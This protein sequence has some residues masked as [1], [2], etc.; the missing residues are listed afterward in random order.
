[1]SSAEAWREYICKACGYVYRERDGDIDSGLAP[2]TRF[3]EIPD[4]WYCPICGVTKSDFVLVASQDVVVLTA[5]SVTTHAMSRSFDV[6]VVGGGTAAWRCV[7]VLRSASTQLS[8]AI[9]SQCAADRYDKPLLS[10]AMAKRLELSTLATETGKACAERLDVFLFS[11]T[12]AIS[13][14]TST[15]TL[16]TTLGPFRYKKLVIAHG[17]QAVLPKNLLP[18]DCWRINHL[19]HYLRFRQYL[20]EETRKVLIVGAGLI[21]SELANDLAIGGHEVTL[22]DTASRP[23]ASLIS[24]EQRCADL[25]NAWAALPIQ[26]IGNAEVMAVVRTAEEKF[27]VSFSHGG[28]KTVD[29][30][31]V[32][33]GLQTSD[34]LART[35]GL[36]WN[37][38]IAVD[39]TTLQTS[40]PD[41]FAIGDCISIDGRTSRYIEPIHRQALTVASQIS[42]LELI[43][44]VNQSVPVRIK[45]SSL[46]MTV[47]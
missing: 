19:S 13:L 14:D 31:V 5:A 10:V 25:M 43:P 46:P 37:N 11:E 35:A 47:N 36:T 6:I 9:I 29:A 30:I 41:V 16:R 26:F 12:T 3:E 40:A 20:G 32:A 8:I 39:Q 18:D 28:T 17:A 24:N 1:M 2:G 33:I 21:G 44:Y 34:R 23:L 38:G 27:K 45:T 22:L 7:Q 4:D 15:K 42:G